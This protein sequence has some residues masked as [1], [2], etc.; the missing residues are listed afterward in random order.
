MEHGKCV[1]VYIGII[2]IINQSHVWFGRPYELGRSKKE[3]ESQ[4]YGEWVQ[5]HSCNFYW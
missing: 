2:I 1:N 4:K 3:M 5:A